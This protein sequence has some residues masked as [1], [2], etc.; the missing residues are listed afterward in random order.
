MGVDVAALG[1]ASAGGVSLGDKDAGFLLARVFDVAVVDAAVAQFSVVEVG[2]LGAFAGELG[3]AGHGL[4][5]SFVFLDFGEDGFGDVGIFVEE[6]VEFC[7]EEVADVFVDADAIGC[8]G[9]GAEFDF[10]LAL[11][12]GFFDVDGDGGDESIADV[13]G[14]EGFSG[15]FPDG[16][17]DVFF[18]CALVCSSLCGVLSVDEG[19]VF[20]AVL[21]GVC[22][23]DFDV[24]GG[25]VYDGVEA[26]VGHGVLQEVFESVSREDASSVADDGEA[27]VEVGV[28]AQHVLYD[29]VVESVVEEH[30]VV[31]CEGDECAAFVVGGCGGVGDELSAFEDG[32]AYLGVAV[33]A[34]LESCAEG[35]DGF[36]SDAVEPDAFFEGFGVVFSSGVEHA[37]GFDE[38]SLGDASSVVSYGDAEVVVDVDVD[39][40]SGVHFEFVDGVVDDFFEENVDAVFGEG[41]VAESSDVHA[42]S[43]AD[44]FHIGEV[45][46]VIVVVN[47]VFVGFHFVVGMLVRVCVCSSGV[48]CACVD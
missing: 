30:G 35:I 32:C 22:E 17:G 20:F 16:F 11:E 47:D 25:E 39:A 2:F 46:D 28:V 43:R 42:R 29:V 8:H 33:G 31:G 27:G 19:V 24:V 10:G 40:F 36:E 3:D 23:G 15:K 18:E 44:V 34:H 38:L 48:V 41:A 7:F 1:D 5:L 45:A 13:A 21:V 4:S 12:H 26:V 6:V 37:D 9:E 14:V